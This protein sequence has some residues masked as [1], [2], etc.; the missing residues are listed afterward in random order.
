MLA[1]EYRPS[2]P[3]HAAARVSRRAGRG[4]LRLV[5]AAPPTPPTPDWLVVR[6]R[7]AGICG[8]D[9]ALLDGTASP[10]LAAL[11]SAPFVPG[12]EVVGEVRGP[13]GASQRVV[14]QPALGCTARGSAT[15][16]PECGLGAEA[17]CRHV[18]DGDVA[19]GLQ[20]GFCRDTGGGWSEALVGHA[21]QLH[22]VPDGLTD[23][24]AVLVEPLACALHA[25]RRADLET[26]AVV[27]VVGAGA[28]GLLVVA[29]LRELVPAVTVLTVAKHPAQALEARRLGADDAC[30]PERFALEAARL[31]G[32]RRLVGPVGG[33]LLLGGLDAVLDCVGSSASLRAAV[34]TTRPRG[35]V[36]MVGMPGAVGVDLSPAWQ[37]ELELR[38]AYGYGDEDFPEAIAVA[39]RLRPGR[40][41]GDGFALHDFRAALDS[42]AAAGRGGRARTVFDLRGKT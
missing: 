19:A 28:I 23:E 13:G 24:D 39:E 17:L 1:L 42:A 2:A 30:T 37:R 22:A 16:C 25:V 9:Q 6:P 40:L 7:L 21:S 4:A 3:R 34:A 18:V 5:D 27:A 8:S 41:V 14:V 15:P 33:E 36:V 26:D 38:G 31:T 12:H 20:I 29:A 11:T 32:G 35:T 10:L